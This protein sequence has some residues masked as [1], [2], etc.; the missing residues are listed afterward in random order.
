[1]RTII[2]ILFSL[3]F[4]TCKAQEKLSNK[5][6][7][8]KN[9]MELD[10]IT[11]SPNIKLFQTKDKVGNQT[12]WKLS[13]E[14]KKENKIILLD[15]YQV[16]HPD[17][18]A[19]IASDNS[20]LE[21]PQLLSAIKDDTNIY[22]F[23][24]KEYALWLYEYHF[25]VGE[26]NESKR[27]K[28]FNMLPGSVSNFGYANFN[29][30][31]YKV[32]DLNYFNIYHHR[33]IG[34]IEM[35]TRFDKDLFT[36][37]KLTFSDK[38][39]KIKDNKQFIRTLDLDKNIEKVSTEIKNI[40]IDNKLLDK[41]NN[42]KYLGNI[43]VSDFKDDERYKIRATGMTYFFYQDN[44]LMKKIIRYNNYE[45]EWLIGNYTEEEIKQK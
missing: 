10:T 22:T 4:F 41:I 33:V 34:K 18:D 29:I 9:K 14:N 24:F 3:L 16:T 39:I 19:I 40:L 32:S 25:T 35:L 36:I 23:I 15:S 12:N 21:I 45:N 42:F 30:S 20:I 31:H 43:D 8:I 2:Y 13:L 1:M 5:P 27:I 11:L 17:A 26:K 6:I 38:I 7:K 44:N 37:K 28:V